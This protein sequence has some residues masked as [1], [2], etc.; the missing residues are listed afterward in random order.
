MTDTNQVMLV[1]LAKQL[2][3][4]AERDRKSDENPYCRIGNLRA[5]VEYVAEQLERVSK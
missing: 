4:A 5:W 1:N 2:R 3:G